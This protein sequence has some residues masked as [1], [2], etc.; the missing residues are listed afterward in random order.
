[1]NPGTCVHCGSVEMVANI[2]VGQT[3]ETGDVG[4]TYTTVIFLDGAEPLLADLCTN[5][6][7]VARLHVVNAARKW[8]TRNA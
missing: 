7:S 4:L 2:P 3:A 1:M 6:G 8:Q 5:C